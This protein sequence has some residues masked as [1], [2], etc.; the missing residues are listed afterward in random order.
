MQKIYSIPEIIETLKRSLMKFFG[1]LRQNIL[2]I[3]LWYSLAPLA[4]PF[5]IH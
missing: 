5:L 3:K 1:I 2:D 4:S